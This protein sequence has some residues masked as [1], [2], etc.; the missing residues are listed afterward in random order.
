MTFLQEYFKLQKDYEDK[1]GETVILV[2]QIGSFYETYEYIL[3]KNGQIINLIGESNHD[4]LPN[5]SLEKTIGKATEVACVL[6][7]R[8]TARDTSKPHSITNPLLCGI[9]CVSFMY[10]KE[11]L[12]YSG[13]TIVVM[14]QIGTKEDGVIERRIVE[15]ITPAT[16]NLNVNFSNEINIICLYIDKSKNIGVS[17]IDPHTGKTCVCE[18]YNRKYD[19]M[20][21]LQEITRFITAKYPK[22]IIVYADD[23]MEKELENIKEEITLNIKFIHNKINNEYKNISYQEKFF[24]KAFNFGEENPLIELEIQDKPYGRIS[25]ILLL[26]YCYEHDETLIMNLTKPDATWIN[27]EG[28]CILTHNAIQQFD[29]MSTTIESAGLIYIHKRRNKKNLPTSLFELLNNS[30]TKLGARKFTMLFNP[31]TD[32][33]KLNWYYS[34]TEYFCKEKE[35]RAKI[36]DMLMNIID[37][38]FIHRKVKNKTITPKQLS[39]LFYSYSIILNIYKMIYQLPECQTMLLP[40]NA[41]SDFNILYDKLITLFDFDNCRMFAW[42][43]NGEFV[44]PAGCIFKKGYYKNMDELSEKINAYRNRLNDIVKRVNDI[45]STTGGKLV[46]LETDGTIVLTK[47]KYKK[48]QEH[49]DFCKEVEFIG[50]KTKYMINVKGV[51]EINECIEELNIKMKEEYNNIIEIF[52]KAQ[53]F[54]YMNNFIG[55]LDYICTNAYNACTMKYYKPKI[56][57][58]ENSKLEIKNLRHPLS[59][60]LIKDK[61]IPNDI[62]LENE[63]MLLYGINSSG[64]TCLTKSV[65]LAIIMAQAG[66]FTAGEIE[67]VPYENIITRLSGNDNL[68][69]G[70]S[71]FIVEMSELRTILRNAGNRTLVLGD[72]LCR[73]TESIS[74]IS[75]TIAT[76]D[77]LIKRGTAFIFSTHMHELPDTEYIKEYIEMKKLSIWHLGFGNGEYERKLR[78]GRGRSTYGI[79]VC[80]KLNISNEFIEKAN[81]IKLKLFGQEEILK[82][83]VSR[84][85]NNVYMDSCVRCGRKQELHTHHI[86]EQHKADEYGI[87]EHFHKNKEFNL[88]VVCNKCHIEIHKSVI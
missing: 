10:H 23:I 48:L 62:K 40:P 2:I 3:S 39:D 5:N 17:C 70:E 20:F 75:L 87:I 82:T 63:G 65:G 71:S 11:R 50:M 27:K 68:I 21:S 78:E 67:Y 8:I 30:S 85:N 7:F 46:Q 1:F 36:R 28:H 38:E 77:E 16:Y 80:K 42:T 29:L 84:Y 79:E 54:N 26:Q 69:K 33:N 53:Y 4:I 24:K 15:I 52:S 83:K 6:G 35:L 57:E 34:I 41:V 58:N 32:K 43:A 25:Y 61:F 72:E 45:C 74:G 37:I 76:I 73:G 56:I 59:E 51:E 47:T 55:E 66:M 14:D 60:Q 9:P 19:D 31:I 44:T 49:I 81:K 64:K 12:I 22:E 86:E 13:Y 88:L 18:I